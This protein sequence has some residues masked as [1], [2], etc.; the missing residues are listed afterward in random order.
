MDPGALMFLDDDDHLTRVGRHRIALDAPLGLRSTSNEADGLGLRPKRQVTML[1]LSQNPSRPW[2]EP[3]MVACF[4]VV[5][6][7]DF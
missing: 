7:P 6:T 2:I 1:G 3:S 4:L 5:R